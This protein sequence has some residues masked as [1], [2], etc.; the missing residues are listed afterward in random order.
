MTGFARK[1]EKTH[2]GDIIWEIRSVNHR[3]L[4]I[5]IRL[6]DQFRAFES[7]LR[8]KIRENIQRGKIE[9]FLK[10]VDTAQSAK[11]IIINDSVVAQLA[12]SF[13]HLEKSISKLNTINPLEILKWPGVVQER[14]INLDEMQK[15]MLEAF[16]QTLQQ[17]VKNRLNEGN[18]IAK[19]LQ[20]KITEIQTILNKIKNLAP[21]M[22]TQLR[23]R[24]TQRFEELKLQI[25]STRLEQEMVFLA[26]KLDINEEIDRLQIHLNETSQALEKGGTIGR[27]L[28]FLIQELHREANTIAAKS[29]DLDISSHTVN[30]RV[31]IEQMREQVQNIE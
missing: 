1:S 11:N 2:Y 20:N 14:D 22:L 4:E 3:F 15:E 5:S 25:E 16:A 28:D 23:N 17:L 19:I 27:R 26:Q 18:T 10:F 12:K 29:S 24:I 31:L 21:E 7:I 8:D 13:S 9:C 6:P 30:L